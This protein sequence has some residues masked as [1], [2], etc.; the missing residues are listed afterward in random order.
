MKKY[1]DVKRAAEAA[2]R[3]LCRTIVDNLSQEDADHLFIELSMSLFSASL[4]FEL[5][6]NEF[7][8][9]LA[10]KQT[11]F[12]FEVAKTIIEYKHAVDAGEGNDYDFEDI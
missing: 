1:D 4:D 6:F 2:L 12:I 10:H 11:V 7:A 3:G 9:E 5:P 8:G